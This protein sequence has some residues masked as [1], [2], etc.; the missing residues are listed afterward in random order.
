MGKGEGWWAHLDSNPL[1][2]KIRVAAKA[3]EFFSAFCTA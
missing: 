1:G 2:A 3:D